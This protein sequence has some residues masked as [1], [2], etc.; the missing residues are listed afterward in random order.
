MGILIAALTGVVVFEMLDLPVFSRIGLPHEVC[1]VQQ[2]KLVW[3]HVVSDLLIGAAYVS[4]SL[5][6]GYLVYKASRD[7]P[8]N[9]V[10]LAFGLFIVSC[11][12]TH[13]MEVLVVWNPVYWLSGYVKVITAAASIVTAVAL[14]PLMPKIFELIAAARQGEAHRKE[15]E[16]LNEDLQRFN[17]SVAHDLRAPLRSVVGYARILR[18]DH[19][20]QLTPEVAKYIS[21]MESSAEKMDG[22]VTGLLRYATI[23]SQSID[24][25]AVSIDDAVRSALG[26]LDHELADRSAQVEIP[27]RLPEVVGDMTLL[28]LVFQNLI[29]NGIKFVTPG[30]RPKVEIT[31]KIEGPSVVVSVTDNGIGFPPDAQA[32]VF[33]MFERFHPEHPGTGI[34]LALVQRAVN[35][36]Q[37]DIWVESGPNGAGSRINVRLRRV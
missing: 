3:L 23:G 6:L 28:Q 20:A 30:V 13:F 10:L 37:G 4:I 19:E 2:P 21:R 12:F 9:W 29:G 27:E 25:V 16:R 7:I 32:R 5:T 15:I 31:A 14:F 26:L 36:M 22:L 1:Y 11:G 24:L 17:Y 8:F 34:G 33:R 18:E 35:R